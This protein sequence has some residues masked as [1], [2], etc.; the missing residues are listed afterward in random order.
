MGMRIAQCKAQN[1]CLQSEIENQKIEFQEKIQAKELRIEDLE[2]QNKNIQ[3]K[4]QLKME[5]LETQNEKILEKF[6]D[7]ETSNIKVTS[8]PYFWVKLSCI[9]LMFL[10]A[11][12]A[13]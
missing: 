5:D 12:A 11:K 6:D 10:A 1:E 13:Q 9:C 2:T 7:Q 3:E 4:L 8:L